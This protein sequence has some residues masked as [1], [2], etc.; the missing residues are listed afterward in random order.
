MHM[1]LMSATIDFITKH[2]LLQLYPPYKNLVPRFRNLREE[3][4]VLRS[5]TIFS[6]L[7]CFIL[8]VVR[9]LNFQEL[10]AF[11]TSLALGFIKDMNRIF[12]IG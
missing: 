3:G 5:K 6:F 1:M 7:G 8:R 10:D 11:V 12:A 2:G 4:R 9:P